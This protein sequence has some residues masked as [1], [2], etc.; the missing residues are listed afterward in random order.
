[1]PRARGD[2]V[3]DGVALGANGQA[4]GSVFD[5][6]AGE[7]PAVV[8]QQRSA[9][10]EPAIRTV[11]LLAGRNRGFPQLLQWCFVDQVCS[12]ARAGRASLGQRVM[13]RR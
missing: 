8:G 4:I 7:D 10:G 9:D 2:G 13:E 5:V 12:Q 6:A 11:G 3:E 1:M